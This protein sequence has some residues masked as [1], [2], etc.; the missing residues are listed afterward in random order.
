MPEELDPIWK[1][2]A[3][4][5]RRKILDTLRDGPRSTGEIVELFPDLTRFGVM[6]HLEVL[7]EAG[8]VRTRQEGRRKVN[9]INV[10]PIRQIYE[11]WVS[12]YE[13]IWASQ[14]LGV[15][16]SVENSAKDR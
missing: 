11:R 1:A 14:L 15:K 10:I 9:T 13:D 16:K 2:L 4:S 8:L 3:D 7:R 5:T 6:K 12:Q